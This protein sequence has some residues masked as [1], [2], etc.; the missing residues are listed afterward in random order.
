MRK[1]LTSTLCSLVASTFLA[2]TSCAATP[3]QQT[4]PNFQKYKQNSYH[5]RT[6]VEVFDNVDNR[7]EYADFGYG[8]AFCLDKGY[9]S[10]FGT[11]AHVVVPNLEMILPRLPKGTEFRGMIY[12]LNDGPQ[13]MDPSDDKR[14]TLKYV[15]E[16]ADVA[17]LTYDSTDVLY[18]DPDISWIKQIP[19]EKGNSE[20]GTRMFSIGFPM[21]HGLTLET[22]RVVSDEVY[23]PET[24]R[25]FWSSMDIQPGMSGAPVYEY[26][27]SGKVKFIGIV[28]QSTSVWNKSL[29]VLADEVYDALEK[30]K[31]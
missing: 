2:I 4:E 11:A 17:I 30:A 15:S 13:D 26:D 28:S 24:G 16:T 20:F 18:N 3:A 7:L 9:T 10:Y 19:D 5:V 25:A 14:L 6:L 12:L 29:I 21:D 1:K 22:G 8:T 23:S 31:E 27:D